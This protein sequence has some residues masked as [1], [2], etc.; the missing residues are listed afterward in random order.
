MFHRIK[1]L[2]LNFSIKHKIS[3]WI[4]GTKYIWYNVQSEI[5]VLQ[6]IHSLYIY[7]T[8]ASKWRNKEKCE[9]IPTA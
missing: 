8:I 2:S 3:Q 4:H 9:E 7:M 6:T 1:Q 5:N